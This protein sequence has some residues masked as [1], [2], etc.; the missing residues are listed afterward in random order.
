MINDRVKIFYADW[1]DRIED[2]INKWLE[3]NPQYY[4]R[5]IEIDRPQHSGVWY[6]YAWYTVMNLEEEQ[7]L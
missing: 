1:A 7:E 5:R 6:G 2:K 3:E 4:I